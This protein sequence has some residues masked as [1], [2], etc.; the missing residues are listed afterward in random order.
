MTVQL[1]EEVWA[2]ASFRADQN[3]ELLYLFVYLG[4]VPA[5][6]GNPSAPD[7][8]LE[9]SIKSP[10]YKLE[11]WSDGVTVNTTVH[12]YSYVGSIIDGWPGAQ[13]GETTHAGPRA[14]V[15][16]DWSSCRPAGHRSS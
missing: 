4:P 12:Q 14:S 1:T 7:V 16:I 9:L 6:M 8:E 5:T 3:V 2:N 13:G 10:V 15:T 11:R